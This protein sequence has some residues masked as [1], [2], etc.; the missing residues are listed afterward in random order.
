MIATE[1]PIEQEGTFPLPEA[2]LDRF[3][4]QTGL[5]YPAEDEEVSIVVA[6]R[7]GHPLDGARAGDLRRRGARRCSARSRTSTWTT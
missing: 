1:N 6:Q 4:L 7:H 3:A 5:G 2:Q